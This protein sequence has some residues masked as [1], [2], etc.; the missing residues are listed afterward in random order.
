LAPGFALSVF[1]LFAQRRDSGGGGVGEADPVGLAAVLGEARG[2]GVAHHGG[3]LGVAA[4][5][6]RQLDA[7]G[8]PE[9]VNSRPPG[10]R[11]R[12]TL[13]HGA[14]ASLVATLSNDAGF[15]T[16]AAI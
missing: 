11:M 12:L 9:A 15:W 1:G 5:S 14:S 7:A 8:M 16:P 6:Q 2:T 10:C 3:A 13:L 4:A